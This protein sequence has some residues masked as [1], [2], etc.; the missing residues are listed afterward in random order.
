M[1][2]QTTCRLMRWICEGRNVGK[3]FDT[4]SSSAM[5]VRERGSAVAAFAFMAPLLVTAFLTFLGLIL[6]LHVRAV[7]ADAA[8]EGA[9]YG[10]QSAA[11]LAAAEKR[12]RDLLGAS[13]AAEYAV[14]ISSRI[15]E[16]VGVQVVEVLVETSI[17]LL[18]GKKTM[19]VR[20][21]APVE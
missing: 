11:G 18:P 19:E 7:A 8:A 15:N 20:G 6:T 5:R 4:A 21:H 2:R 17:P 14:G 10:A 13:F 3:A 1:T 12:T 9:R 16:R